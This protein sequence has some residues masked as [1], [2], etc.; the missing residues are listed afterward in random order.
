MFMVA[1]HG[2]VQIRINRNDGGV[3]LYDLALN[4]DSWD[5]VFHANVLQIRDALRGV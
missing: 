3:I 1:S 2:A 5:L 4:V